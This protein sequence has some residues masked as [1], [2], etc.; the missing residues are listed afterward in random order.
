MVKNHFS[1]FYTHIGKRVTGNTTQKRR[2]RVV[3]KVNIKYR[4]LRVVDFLLPTF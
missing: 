4:D 1:L 3:Q 2:S